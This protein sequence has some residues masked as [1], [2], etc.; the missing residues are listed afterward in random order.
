MSEVKAED[1]R[2]PTFLLYP[3]LDCAWP[4]IKHPY[5]FCR[6]IKVLL[7]STYISALCEVELRLNRL[8]KPR[9]TSYLEVSKAQHRSDHGHDQLDFGK[10]TRKAWLYINSCKSHNAPFYDSVVIL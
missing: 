7:G 6:R 5:S 2:G 8:C 4:V 3:E 9:F 1:S 10:A